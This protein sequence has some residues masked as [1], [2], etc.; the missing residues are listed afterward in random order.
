MILRLQ[1]VTKRFGGLTAVDNVSIDV[2]RGSIFALIGPN[3]AGKTTLFNTIT[4]VFHATEGSIRFNGRDISR[5]KPHQVA[6]RGVGRTFQNIRLFGYMS[7]LDNVRVAQDS[8]LHAHLWSAMFK[9]PFE[10][11]EERR[12]R[13]RAMDLLQFVGIDSY[14]DRTARSLPYGLQRGLEVARA[15]A[16]DPTLLLLDEPAAGFNPQEKV[17]LM[18]LMRRIQARGTTVFLIEHD[19]K[20]VMGAAERIAV[21]DYGVKIAEGEPAEVRQDPRVIEAYLGAD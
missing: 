3:G 20:V 10:R 16:T 19:M 11:A 13:E 8:R 14:A 21:L 6:R 18:D 5:L 17:A 2:K 9:T 7:A 15:L 12:V 4:G 1:S